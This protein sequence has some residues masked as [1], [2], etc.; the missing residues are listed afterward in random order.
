MP[1]SPFSNIF[2]RS[3]FVGLQQHMGVVTECAREVPGLVDALCA[4]DDAALN[5]SAERIFKL[6]AD[7]D[8]AK[9]EVRAHMPR[10]LFMPV[11][12]RDLLEILQ[13]QDSIADTAQDIAELFIER[14]MK[15]PSE[16]DA[17]LKE[18]VAECVVVVVNAEVIVNRLD[19]LLQV[20]FR[21]KQA[22]QVEALLDELNK[23]ED[24]TDELEMVLTRALFEREDELGPVTVILWYRLIEW[25]GDLADHAEKVGNRLRLVIAR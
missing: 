3:P 17:P 6:E 2:G 21:G 10:S 20:G 8:L 25:I 4:G 18:L 14:D 19:E 16:L 11:D 24:R 9:H 22:E 15:L 1:T 23:S 12:R 7:A 5:A 13:S